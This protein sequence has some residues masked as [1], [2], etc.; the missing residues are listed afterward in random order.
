GLL[1]ELNANILNI[2]HDRLKSTLKLG[3]TEVEIAV[4]TRNKEHNESIIVG[5]KSEG[6]DIITTV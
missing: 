6:Y 4:E 3:Q 2:N 1:F 5:L